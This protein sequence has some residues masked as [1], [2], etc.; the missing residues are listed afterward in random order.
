M[1]CEDVKKIVEA[2]EEFRNLFG[3]EELKQTRQKAKLSRKPYIQFLR[4]EK[5][6]KLREQDGDE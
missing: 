1:W 3:M 5:A 6:R 4:D 2:E